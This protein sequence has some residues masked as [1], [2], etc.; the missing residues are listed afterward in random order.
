MKNK[1]LWGKCV[2]DVMQ[3]KKLSYKDSEI[4][5]CRNCGYYPDCLSSFKYCA[6][7]GD[8]LRD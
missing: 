2:D 7:D 3:M 4:T 1:T 5:S 6:F 8:R